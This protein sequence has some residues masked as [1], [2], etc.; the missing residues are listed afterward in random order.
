MSQIRVSKDDFNYV[1]ITLM[2]LLME[3]KKWPSGDEFIFWRDRATLDERK[4]AISLLS[5]KLLKYE[6]EI[7]KVHCVNILSYMDANKDDIID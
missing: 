4:L 6:K 1:R 2:E 7:S 5:C 3:Q